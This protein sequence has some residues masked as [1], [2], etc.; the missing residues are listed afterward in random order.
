LV[1]WCFPSYAVTSWFCCCVSN[2]CH[3]LGGRGWLRDET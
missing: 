2:N 1:S 3:W